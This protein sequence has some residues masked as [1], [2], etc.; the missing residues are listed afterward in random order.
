MIM[1]PAIEKSP[2][3]HEPWCEAGWIPMFETLDS[4]GNPLRCYI[5]KPD[6]DELERNRKGFRTFLKACWVCREP[7]RKKERGKSK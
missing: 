7:P 4:N 6:P 1:L 2:L 3:C 5:G